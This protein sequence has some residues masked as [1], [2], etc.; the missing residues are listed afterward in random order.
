MGCLFFILKIKLC[1]RLSDLLNKGI[2]SHKVSLTGERHI[3]QPIN[4]SKDCLLGKEGMGWAARGFSGVFLS[5]RDQTRENRHHLRP[6]QHS[7]ILR[8]YIHFSA[9]VS[10]HKACRGAEGVDSMEGTQRESS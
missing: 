4:F 6:R 10:V 3:F 1:A 5:P 7:Y 2:F 9:P 8:C